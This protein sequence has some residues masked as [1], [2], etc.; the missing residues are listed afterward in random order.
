[1]IDKEQL[2]NSKSFCILPFINARI[3]HSMVVPCC[4]N[5]NIV[6]GIS[7]EQSLDEIY[8]NNNN[9]LTAFRHQLLE[10]NE[11]PESCSRCTNCEKSNVV[12]MRQNS[13]KKWGHLLKELEFDSDNNLVEN[14]F[15]LW[16]GV[17]F[18][19]LCNLKCRMCPSYLSSSTREEEIKHNLTPKTVSL[20][21]TE[22]I[23]NYKFK[24]KLNGI[25]IESFNN[26]NDFYTFFLKHINYIKEIKFEGGEPLMLPQHYKIL[27][28]LI[29]KNKTDVELS[30]PTNLT[31]LNFKSYNVLDLW[32]KF[33]NINLSISIDAYEDQNYYIRHPSNWN[34]IVNNINKVKSKCPHIK[35]TISTTI[36]IL[37]SFAATKVHAWALKNNIPHSFVFLKDPS[38][39]SL[40]S[41]PP[42][43]KQRVQTHWDL[44]K[45]TLPINFDSY[46]IDDFLK[47]MWATD[48]SNE[49]TEFL[50]KIK[51]RDIIRNESLLETFPEFKDL[52]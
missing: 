27:E 36:Q 11:L 45:Q 40:C 51:E 49:I 48:S 52:K 34:D 28:L 29:E 1:M 21:Q 38:Y 39:F 31:R 37:N 23:K 33:N 41:L 42:E 3:W 12:S 30:Y 17:G 50:N 8:S 46:K 43:Y 10:G 2:L 32:N 19:N 24:E 22:F 26:E 14:K 25:T 47:M 18:S 13:N 15:Y 4:I 35:L 9:T 7:T 44:Y 16:D 5:H 20:A 6:F